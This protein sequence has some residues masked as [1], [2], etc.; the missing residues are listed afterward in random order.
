[1]PDAIALFDSAFGCCSKLLAAED[2]QG[3]TEDC[4]NDSDEGRWFIGKIYKNICPKGDIAIG[5]FII[6]FIIG[7]DGKKI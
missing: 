4:P 6:E 1:S 3:L 5:N 7:M 2:K